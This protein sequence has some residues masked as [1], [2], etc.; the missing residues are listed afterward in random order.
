M[1]TT[2][3]TMATLL[4]L[5]LP[6]AAAEAAPWEDDPAVL[7]VALQSGMHFY[8]DAGVDVLA[9]YPTRVAARLEAA[10]ALAPQWRVGAQIGGGGVLS[11]VHQDIETQFSTFEL[12]A[13]AEYQ[14]RLLPALIAFG[15]LGPTVA[16]YDL[17]LTAEG[18]EL[19]HEDWSWGGQAAVG[20]TFLPLHASLGV[21]DDDMG[22]LGLGITAAFTY[23][24]MAPLDI[25][26]AGTDLG[27]LD[28]SGYGWL[29]GVAAQF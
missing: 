8:E 25:D 12:G 9:S 19:V 15:K 17:T 5:T 20:L 23:T 1:S 29:F 10:V 14:H 28:P 11:D 13:F 3:W 7:R 2:T 18:R 27:T 26:A 6:G 24:R 22:D 21:L 4:L 16:W